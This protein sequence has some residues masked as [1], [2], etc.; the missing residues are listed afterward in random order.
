MDTELNRLLSDALAKQFEA[1]ERLLQERDGVLQTLQEQ[2]SAL[3][4]KVVNLTKRL[5]GD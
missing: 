1:L 2:V 4:Q 3:Q 5:S